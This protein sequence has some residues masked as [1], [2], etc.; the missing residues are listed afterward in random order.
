MPIPPN[1][2]EKGLSQHEMAIKGLR[3]FTVDKVNCV[4]V[5]DAILRGKAG[6]YFADIKMLYVVAGNALN[7]MCDTNNAVRAL[8]TLQFVVV[9]DQF[10]TPT[11]KFAD[12]LLPAT[13]FCE[14]NDISLPWSAGC[15]ICKQS[16]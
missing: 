9:H 6:G 16:D 7:Q 12:I 8:K 10:M 5:W 3:E 13:T 11:A 1:P 15:P 2:V 4:K 14:R